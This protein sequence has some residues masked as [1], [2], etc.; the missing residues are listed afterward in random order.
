MLVEV[1]VKV[2]VLLRAALALE[3]VVLVGVLVLVEHLAQQILVVV[4]VVDFIMEV[5][6]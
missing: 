3:A 5:Q 6:A 1:V 4:L 2:A